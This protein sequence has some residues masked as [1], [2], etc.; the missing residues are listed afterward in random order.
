MAVPAQSSPGPWRIT[1]YGPFSVAI[2]AAD[3]TVIY[4][5]DCEVRVEQNRT[6]KRLADARSKSFA[7]YDAEMANARLIVAV[8]EMIKALREARVA[9]DIPDIYANFPVGLARTA[10]LVA[11]E[12]AGAA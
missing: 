2:V 12:T 10:I 5:I 3:N 8:P 1:G 6:D 11:L 7:R 4:S 9:L